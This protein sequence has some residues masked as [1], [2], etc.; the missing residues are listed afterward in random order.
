[1]EHPRVSRGADV[2]ICGGGPA[3]AVAGIVLARAGARVRL[4]D[5]ARFPR[6]KLCGDSVNPGAIAV[7]RRLGLAGIAETGLAL[8]G[9]MVTGDSGVS[10]VGRYGGDVCGRTLPRSDLDMA[11]LRAACA[12]G[13]VVEE[14]TLVHGPA[15][16]G[17]KVTGL[18]V[19][20][21]D[22]R[23]RRLTAAI[24]IAAD[25]GRSRI[26]RALSLA[27]HPE[28]PRRWAVGAYFE[29]VEGTSDLG[30]MHV[31]RDRYIGV[32]P[33]PGGLTNAC[34]VSADRRALADPAALL[35]R[36]LRTDP[37]LAGR[38]ARSRRVTRPQCLGPL[39][40]ESRVCGAPGLLLAG[41]AAGFIDPMTGDGLRF[42][43]RG[44]ELAAVEALLALEH[45]GADAH[46]RLA[47][48]REREFA[49][50]W[51]FNRALRSL[52]GWPLGV[53]AA[54]IGARWAPGWLH[55]T[56]RYAGDLQAA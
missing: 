35:E 2:L 43:L 30:E 11:L 27:C 7:L 4:L 54:A 38:F 37:A 50:K 12:A 19:A 33:L 8:G 20:G 34:V 16:D 6:D 21:H 17:D 53:R 13:V 22:G 28:R 41:D 25:G 39:A 47:A 45:G 56:I 14:G 42:A 29:D 55:Q 52:V 26:A 40:V 10:V 46:L 49:R 51:R 32:A 9:M 31:R 3:G 23:S 1:M 44:A 5:R 36:T 18:L 24:T 48:A 15:C